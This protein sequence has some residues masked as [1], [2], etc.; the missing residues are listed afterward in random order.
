MKAIAIIPA[1]MNSSRFPGKPMAN[2][3]G[4]PMIGHC[5]H[6]V[7]MCFDLIDTYV[8]T[9]DIEIYEYIHSIGGKAIMTS[10]NHERASDRAAEAMLKI[11]VIINDKVDVV[12]MV[13]G[14]EPM[15]TPKMISDALIPLRTNE[16]INVVNLMAN[17]NSIE[18][19][20]DP[21]EVKVV[22]DKFS[23]AMYFS[24]E[25]IPSTKKG[26]QKKSM[27]K[28]VCIIPFRRD[29]LIKFNDTPETLTEIIES[30]DMMRVIENGEKVCMVMTHE[31]SYSVDTKEDL[32]RV[33]KIMNNDKL[34]KQ[35]LK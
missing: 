34:M 7:N 15:V 18:E 27:L 22:I 10:P 16:N 12:V 21:N 25:P 19:F 9:C 11:E 8:A 32:F 35:Y 26:S 2:I 33:Q 1:R 6:R 4:V 5:Y 23:N 24:R 13:Q 29:Y 3:H 28:Q 17:I 30:V 14:D 20:E 31:N